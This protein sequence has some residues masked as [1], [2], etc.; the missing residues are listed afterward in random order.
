MMTHHS[1]MTSLLRIKNK[2]IDKF[3]DFL[4]DIDHNRNTHVF[5]DVIYLIINQCESI[6]PKGASGGYLVSAIRAAQANEAN[7]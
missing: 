4:S 1:V 3:G 7:L 6:R 2:K 5:K